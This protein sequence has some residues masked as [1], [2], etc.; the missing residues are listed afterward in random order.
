[1]KLTVETTQYAVICIERNF[2]ATEALILL[3]QVSQKVEI[4]LPFKG[5]GWLVLKLEALGNDCKFLCQCLDLLG[6]L[7]AK[8]SL[9]PSFKW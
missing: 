7:S 2:E 9:K 3:I 6:E 8:C 4:F 1:M 5:S